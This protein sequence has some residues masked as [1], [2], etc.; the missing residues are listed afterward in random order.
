MTRHE[1][2]ARIISQTSPAKDIYILNV[3]APKI[4]SQAKPGQ[5]CML[6]AAAGENIHDPLLP[7]PLSIHN[8]DSK[9]TVQFLYRRVGKGTAL[10]SAMEKGD[11]LYILGPLGRGFTWSHKGHH[12]IVGGGMGIAPLLFLASAMKNT[13]TMATVILG[14]ASGDDLACLDAYRQV[15]QDS[16]LKIATEDGSA[17]HRGLVT[18]LL[19]DLLD[20]QFSDSRQKEDASVMTCGPWPMMKAVAEICSSHGLPC[21]V[22]LEAHMACGSGLCL[23][24]AVP[25]AGHMDGYVHVCRQ[26]PV[27]NAEAISWECLFRQC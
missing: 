24:C 18:E 2:N 9:T 4:A 16:R 21:Q 7:R 23:G 27:I 5:F 12:V 11:H 14:A 3:E 26:G 25:T 22:S 19:Q 15:V 10:L 17:G 13:G 1:L 6:Q 8:T 20:E